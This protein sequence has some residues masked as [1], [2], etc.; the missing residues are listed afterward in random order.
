MTER[1][2]HTLLFK[3][4]SV[5]LAVLFA[6]FV[7]LGVVG[8]TSTSSDNRSVANASQVEVLEADSVVEAET[9]ADDATPLAAKPTPETAPVI[10]VIGVVG[11][12]VVAG[13]V[14]ALFNRTKRHHY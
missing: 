14:I 2:Q 5:A 6:A 10:A 13:I 12:V 1:T 4:V 3:L 11:A 9:I 7:T 8:I